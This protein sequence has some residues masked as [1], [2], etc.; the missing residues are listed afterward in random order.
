MTEF[1]LLAQGL[2]LE[3][4][5]LAELG[6]IGALLTGALYAIRALY[7]QNIKLYDRLLES[8]K[9]H[10][11]ELSKR[12]DKVN[13]LVMNDS[14]VLWEVLMY[15]KFVHSEKTERYDEYIA[16]LQDPPLR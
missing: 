5:G 10:L 16:N 2:G 6:L 9:A 12:D 11:E 7:K 13:Q 1:L 15:L 3:Q 4:F 14:K 8:E